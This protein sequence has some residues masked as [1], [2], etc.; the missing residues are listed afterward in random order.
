ME[1]EEN[2]INKN[3]FKIQKKCK[4][5]NAKILIQQ[6]DKMKNKLGEILTKK[7]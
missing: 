4:K 7:H 6:K 5:K 1:A 3:Q 2:K